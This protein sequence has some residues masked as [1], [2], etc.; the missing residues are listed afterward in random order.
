MALQCLIILRSTL[1]Q[2]Q[3]G[4]DQGGVISITQRVVGRAGSLNLKNLHGGFQR[5]LGG[6][7]VGLGIENHLSIVPSSGPFGIQLMQLEILPEDANVIE[8]PGQE[9]DVLAAPLPELLHRLRERHTLISQAA[10]LDTGEL[11]DPAVQVPVI[12]G[13]DHYLE[14]VSHLLV[15]GHTN[16]ADLDDLTADLH[17]QYLLGRGGT[18][19]GLI[20]FHIHN[21][22][23]HHKKPQKRVSTYF[24]K[25]YHNTFAP[26]L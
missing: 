19:P 15:L 8:A 26:H 14:F 13:L 25:S 24:C 7:T 17:R 3:P 12:F 11:A 23:L 20:P 6:R 22:I 21:N 2:V 10:F 1:L 4:A 9:H 5:L 16:S 18:G